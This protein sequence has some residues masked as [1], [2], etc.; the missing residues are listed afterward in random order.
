MKTTVM[1]MIA[2][3]LVSMTLSATLATL[4]D[5]GME[6]ARGRTARVVS[7]PQNDF[8]GP[9]GVTWGA[10]GKNAGAGATVGDI[11]A[12][13]RPASESGMPVFVSPR[14]DYL[15]DHG[16]HFEGALEALMHGIG[17]SDRTDPPEPEG[18]ER[19]GADRLPVFEPYVEDGHST[20]TGPHE[21]HGPGTNDLVL[22]LCRRGIDK[23]VPAGMSAD[24]CTQPHQLARGSEVAVVSVATAAQVEEGDGFAAAIVNTRFLANA[25]RTA[26]QSVA[27]MRAE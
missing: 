5:P 21:V 19:S 12:P 17:M 16:W 4:P 7:G 23:V 25:M 9:D 10:L 14:Y 24:L 6:T 2:V 22:Q 11:D 8:L 27:A 20:V 3:A 26:G 18:V 15:H 1:T 13:F